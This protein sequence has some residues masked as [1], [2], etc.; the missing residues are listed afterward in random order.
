MSARHG[1][2]SNA[3]PSR[4]L[5]GLNTIFSVDRVSLISRLHKPRRS[6]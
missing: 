3:R 5:P 2:R 6:R 4:L 1:R